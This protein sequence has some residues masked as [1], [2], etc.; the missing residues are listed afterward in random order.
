[1]IINNRYQVTSEIS[2]GS[3]GIIYRGHDTKT[4]EIVAIKIELPGSPSSLK[5]EVKILTYLK[6]SKIKSVPEIYWYGI[7]REKIPCLVMTNY[8]Y[9]LYDYCTKILV[10]IS[11]E[12]IQDWMLQIIKI[13]EMFHKVFLLHR[14]IKPQNIMLKNNRI[15]IIDFGLSAFYIGE[16][17]EHIPDYSIE[18]DI[19]IEN[20]IIGSPKFASIFLHK[21]HRVSRRDDLISTVYLYGFLILGGKTPWFDPDL[22]ITEQNKNKDTYMTIIQSSH[23]EGSHTEVFDWTIFQYFLDYCYQ[24]SYDETPDYDS[25][26]LLFSGIPFTPFNCR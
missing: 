13:I 4:A 18:N 20:R 6:N 2:R 9:S 10:D 17:R 21:G 5:Y 7:F 24:L 26:K 8:E 12:L 19:I 22:Y 14:D 25:L 1:M 15:Y 23:I 11:I 3:F 16:D